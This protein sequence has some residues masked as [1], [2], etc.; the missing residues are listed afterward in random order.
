MQQDGKAAGRL[1]GADAPGL[2]DRVSRLAAESAA[3]A[4]NGTAASPPAAAAV[5]P[6]GDLTSRIKALLSSAPVV[7]FM[8][9]SADSPYCG[10]SRKVVDALRA[11]GVSHFRDFDIFSDEEIR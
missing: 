7:L 8:K 1:E 9:G 3:T 5:P 11:A 6:S 4:A 10:F 2:T